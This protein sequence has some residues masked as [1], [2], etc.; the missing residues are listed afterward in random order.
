MSIHQRPPSPFQEVLI[1]DHEYNVISL[2]PAQAWAVMFGGKDVES[3]SHINTQRGRVL[4]HASS[5]CGTIRQ[6]QDLRAEVSFLAGIAKSEL[7]VSFVRNAILGSVEIVK[8]V[9][10]AR[11]KWA[12]PGQYQWLLEA[13][14]RLAA[15][16][17]G[18]HGE[19][20]SWCWKVPRD[21]RLLTG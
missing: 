8:C 21:P 7:P 9:R 11:S 13:P 10:T 16:V 20:Q 12:V 15:P 2:H 14:R 18:V 17:T 6:E 5:K 3:R 19:L 4:V 1:P